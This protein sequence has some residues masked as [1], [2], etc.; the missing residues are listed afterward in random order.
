MDKGL[1]IS[2]RRALLAA[3]AALSTRPRELARIGCA[4]GG[5]APSPTL[6]QLRRALERGA[7][8]AGLAPDPRRAEQALAWAEAP[9]RALLT[10]ADSDYPPL[11]A[12]APSP[13]LV[14]FVDGVRPEALRAP[15]L[16]VV[17]ARRA[18]RGALEFAAELAADCAG[19][20]IVVTSGL[21]L[22]VDSAAHRGALAGNGLTVA[23]LGCSIDRVYPWRHRGLADA[24]RASG[25]VVSEFP[26]AT[27]PLRH[28][29]PQRNR[30]IAALSHGTLVVEAAARSGSISTAMHALECGREVF[31]VPGAVRNPMAAG[32]HA[33]LRSGAAL[34]CSLD[35]VLDALPALHRGEHARGSRQTVA[36]VAAAEERRL[37]D[38]CG[39]DVFSIDEA[40]QRS[41]LTVQEVCSMLL[42]LELAGA[43]ESRSNG[44]YLRTR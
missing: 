43:I 38:S 39:W 5:G 27:A 19:H 34:A 6:D 33:L 11:L 21:A 25:C 20:D 35:D 40:A 32:C 31:A 14:L 12:T 2:E 10:R 9:D 8:K 13:P 42:K 22:G 15:Q 7:R 29:F 16:A 37:L 4:Y 44:T 30:V 23:V 18:T 26:F 3:H 41:G 1:D 36:Y 24:I 28:H 17:G